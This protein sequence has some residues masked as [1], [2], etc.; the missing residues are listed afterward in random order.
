MHYVA[1]SVKQ[2]NSLELRNGTKEIN[3]GKYINKHLLEFIL[4]TE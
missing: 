4:S 1:L 3:L 2:S